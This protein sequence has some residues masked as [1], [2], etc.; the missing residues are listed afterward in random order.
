M[1]EP[2]SQ[3]KK[4]MNGLAKH[5][6][7][8]RLLSVNS[9]HPKAPVQD[10][11]TAAKKMMGLG[12]TRL[13]GLTVLLA[14]LLP[15]VLPEPGTNPSKSLALELEGYGFPRSSAWRSGHEIN[16]ASIRWAL[17]VIDARELSAEGQC[18]AK[19]I[20][21]EARSEPLEGQLAVAQVVLNR[22]KSPKFPN[23]ICGV[24]YQGE[25]KKHRCQFSFACD[26]V[27]DTPFEGESWELSKRVAYVALSGRWD[28][29]TD[30]AKN[31]HAIYVNPHWSDDLV[32]T[33][34][35]GRHIFYREH[36]S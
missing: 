30:G 24:V 23:T 3:M 14:V 13:M 5:N 12:T 34:Q 21:F 2:R 29:I 17:D 22:V 6:K 20:Y 26:G 4:H 1:L 7:G 31:Y 35:H 15:F 8:K 28:D 32:E 11:A 19:A 27:S 33:G 36:G 25:A 16:L 9:I 18:L 10:L